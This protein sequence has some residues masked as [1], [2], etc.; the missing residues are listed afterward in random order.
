MH[1]SNM[2]FWI[3]GFKSYG[4][5]MFLDVGDGWGDISHKE[6]PFKPL[7]K[8]HHYKVG[9]ERHFVKQQAYWS[10]NF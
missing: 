6:L 5:N 1:K 7:V 8:Y 2:H 9:S 3:F 4:N 10:S